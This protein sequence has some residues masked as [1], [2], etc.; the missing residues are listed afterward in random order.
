MTQ[1][2]WYYS[3]DW[4]LLLRH[5]YKDHSRVEFRGWVVT[6]PKVTPS[7]PDSSQFVPGHS[8][9][10]Y[11]RRR[12]KQSQSRTLSW[13]RWLLSSW[14]WGRVE[15]RCWCL[16][17]YWACWLKCQPVKRVNTKYKGPCQCRLLLNTRSDLVS[18]LF[19]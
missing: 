13:R 10:S 3:L 15:D 9:K 19:Q 16:M 12:R 7:T 17:H 2:P 18:G 6:L 8:N 4:M 1:I 14:D 5:N 11:R